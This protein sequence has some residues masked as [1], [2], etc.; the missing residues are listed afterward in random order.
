MCKRELITTSSFFQESCYNDREKENDISNTWKSKLKIL[1]LQSLM[2][3]NSCKTKT[4]QW[5]HIWFFGAK[6]E[7]SKLSSRAHYDIQK[8]DR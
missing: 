6:V 8:D 4:L 1:S 3:A 5:K 7:G 2:L